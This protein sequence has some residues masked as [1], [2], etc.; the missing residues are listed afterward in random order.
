MILIETKIITFNNE[1]SKTASLS[2]GFSL[3]PKIVVTPADETANI[4]VFI[5]NISH[6]SVTIETSQAYS[7][8]MHIQAI[9]I[10][11]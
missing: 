4:N 10:E 2:G 1:S 7:G 9:S 3:P 5:T 11:G 8:N 6:T